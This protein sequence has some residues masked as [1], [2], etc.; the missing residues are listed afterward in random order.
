MGKIILFISLF[1]ALAAIPSAQIVLGDSPQFVRVVQ[2]QEDISKEFTI[3][4]YVG[5]D[6]AESYVTEVKL[7]YRHT[8]LDEPL[9]VTIEDSVPR[10]IV[11]QA[12][13][14]TFVSQPA[15]AISGQEDILLTWNTNSV[16]RGEEKKFTYRFSR[17]LTPQMISSFDPPK[18]KSPSP[19]E[20][21]KRP[22]PKSDIVASLAGSNPANSPFA[23]MCLGAASMFAIIIALSLVFG[24]RPSKN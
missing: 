23:M 22:E 8:G 16:S 20:P 2:Y 3:Y 13:Q 17:L 5:D 4:K 6:G 21:A 12:S 18:L 15:K 11:S 19:S 7:F 14:I 24:K 9:G 10:S 1:L